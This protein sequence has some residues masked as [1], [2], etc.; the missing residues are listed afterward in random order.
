[1]QR[2]VELAEA[3]SN[4]AAGSKT[5]KLE[6]ARLQEAAE[7]WRGQAVSLQAEVPCRAR[8]DASVQCQGL[9]AD[10]CILV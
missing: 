2:G 8:L 3:N 5:W 9:P 4:A 7:K 6:Q 1:M 10:L